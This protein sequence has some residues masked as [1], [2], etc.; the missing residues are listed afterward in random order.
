M[1][2]GEVDA[3][4][5]FVNQTRTWHARLIPRAEIDQRVCLLELQIRIGLVGMKMEEMTTYVSSRLV[6]S[7]WT[8]CPLCF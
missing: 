3:G 6:F 8:F 1:R 4:S 7:T 2:K 5:L